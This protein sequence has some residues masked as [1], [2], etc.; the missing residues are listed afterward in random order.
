MEHI[1]RRTFLKAAATGALAVG[2]GGML[3]GCA[4]TGSQGAAVSTGNTGAKPLLDFWAFSSTRTAWQE[5]AWELYK[6]DKNPDFEINFLILP[7]N[8][9]HDKVMITSQAGSGGPDIVDIE[10]GQFSRFIKGDVIFVD[11][12]PKLE[13]EGLLD[14]LYLPSA[15]DPWTWQQKI[16]GI[17]NE[18]NAC[19]MSYRWDIYEQ[20]GIQ[21]PIETWDQFV[22]VGKQFHQDTNKYLI[23]VQWDAW[24]Q[25]WMLTLQQGGGFFGPDG[26]PT[27]AAPEGV[28]SLTFQNQAIEDG[29]STLRP[30]GPARNA[31][32][33]SGTIA[34]ILGPSWE[35]SG[36]TRQNLPNTEGLWHLQ[37]FPRWTPDGARTATWGGTGVSVLKT[38]QM[39]EEAVEFVVWEHT[40]T[41]AVMFDY[42]E[43]NV[44]PSY[45]PAFEQPALTEPIAFFDNQRVGELIQQVANEI[46][47]WYNSPFWPET[48]DACV[49]VGITPCLQTDLDPKAALTNAQQEAMNIIDFQKA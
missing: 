14:T 18:L 11:L 27:L 26:L 25:W 24:G 4:S 22:E 17:G 46:P 42:Q 34:T 45:K 29:W 3:S 28:N 2:S 10:I 16:Y 48:T 30:L 49:R 39:A 41:E 43:R 47:A 5:K 20:A 1:S 8:Q 36:F 44:W 37:P 15:T 19:L 23:D 40:T 21:T 12:R 9:M 13:Q 38:S 32:L 31:A 35:F 33:D 6:Q 7:F